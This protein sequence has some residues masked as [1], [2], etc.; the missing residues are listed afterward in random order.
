VTFNELVRLLEANGFT[1]VKQ[2][3]AIR[4]YGRAGW[5]R[6]IRLDYHG[7]KEVPTG[8]YHAI[9]KSAGIQRP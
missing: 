4:Y 5:P 3:G 8:T 6:R 7:G 9:L 2:K 1:L